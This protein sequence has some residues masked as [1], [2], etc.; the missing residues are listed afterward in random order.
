MLA[1]TLFIYIL[2]DVQKYFLTFYIGLIKSNHPHITLLSI[3]LFCNNKVLHEESVAWCF[4]KQA[5]FQASAVIT[6]EQTRNTLCCNKVGKDLILQCEVFVWEHSFN[7][8]L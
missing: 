8:R 4:D 1:V 5:H 2:A 3:S 6:M 7:Y